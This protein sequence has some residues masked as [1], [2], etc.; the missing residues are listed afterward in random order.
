[1]WLTGFDVPCLHTM[2]I[3]K[4]MQGA[5]LMQ[6]IARVNRVYGNKPGGLIVDYI[7]IGQDLRK[8]MGVYTES[9]GEGEAVID[10]SEVIAGMNT[11]FEVVEQM[12]HSF[13]Y[14]KYFKS[15]NK[16]KLK[17]LLGAT[18]FILQTEEL[19]NRFIS[20]ITALTKFF[21][22]AV[23]SFE[24]EQIRDRVAFFQAVKSRIVKFIP[25]GGKSDKQVETA[26]RQIVDEALSSD[27]VVDIFEAAGLKTPTLD[28]LSEEFLLE[29]KN[30]EQKNLAFELLRKLL[31]DEIKVRKRKNIVQ[32][33][34]FSEMLESVIKRYH[35]N[36]IDTAQVIQ[37]LMEIA[38]E[39]KLEDKKA[40]DIGLTPEEF[41]FYSVLL[42][43]ESTK[44]L[45][46]NK[47][48]E[49]IHEIVDVIRRN[50]T[51]DWEKRD[52]VK[53]KLRLTVKKI[54]MKYGYPPDLA[55]LEADRVLRQSELLASELT[56]I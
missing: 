26:V 45:E 28:I 5:N 36:Q 35:N 24:S 37:E 17:I 50:A 44:F 46:D 48:K 43:N 4:K 32:G 21:A 47:M 33:K 13:D 15:E 19:K 11:K 52:D 6:A 56:R 51:V 22:M 20:E 8:A 7:G 34:K 12:F 25:S 16:E 55:R 10:I 18:N 41:A 27:G 49:L 29:V 2:Y 31:N 3:D 9:G 39:L 30:M 14:N 40:K 54:L 38:K 53:A 42:E 1:M 23:P